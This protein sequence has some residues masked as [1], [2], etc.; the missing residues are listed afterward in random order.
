VRQ[1]AG[2]AQ[3]H[4]MPDSTEPATAPDAVETGGST[5]ADQPP[6]STVK[7][8][9]DP[10]TE[11]DPRFTFA[12]ERTFLAWNRTGL[13]LIVA[14]LAVAQF[15]KLGFDGAQLLLALP[16]IALGAGVA[17]G[18]YRLWQRNEQ[19]LRRGEPL[20]RSRLPQTLVF[21]AVALAAIAAG[22]AIAQFA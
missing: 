13:A 18:S 10:E 22:L 4:V 3:T 16:L 20:P 2:E 21:V 11:P 1:A 19:A 14:G 15:L 5:M 12:N 8:Q 9:Q 7:R 17:L 6:R